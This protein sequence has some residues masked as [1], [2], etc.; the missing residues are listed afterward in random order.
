MGYNHPPSGPWIYDSR[1]PKPSCYS[2]FDDLI[3]FSRNNIGIGDSKRFGLEMFYK[4]LSELNIL[5]K[6]KDT[7]LSNKT[8]F[9]PNNLAMKK[10][11]SKLKLLD[12]EEKREF[13]GNHIINGKF[14]FKD[15]QDMQKNKATL[16]TIRNQKITIKKNKNFLYLEFN[17]N[18]IRISNYDFVLDNGYLHHV[19]HVISVFKSD[20]LENK[21]PPAGPWIYNNELPRPSTKVNIRNSLRFSSTSISKEQTGL[22]LFCHYLE[23]YKILNNF[24]NI[25]IK[26]LF[27]HLLIV[28]LKHLKNIF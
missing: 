14:T 10:F 2:N 21:L 20:V 18:S 5:E 13:L 26:L 1:L 17:N 6:D 22:S 11:Y 27:L 25:K 12:S 15:L 9:V 23:K 16:Q 28:P 8:V 19:D 24:N 7:F 3:K 4:F